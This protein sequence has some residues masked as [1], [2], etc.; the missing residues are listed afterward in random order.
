MV[1][2]LEVTEEHAADSPQFALLVKETINTFKIEEISADKAYSSRENHETAKEV[3]AT[4]YV[5]FRN[6]ATGNS[7][8]SMVW[9]KAFLYF[10]LPCR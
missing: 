1:T 10:Q 4:A 6:N 2:A 5:T 8:G 3:G 7:G 9:K